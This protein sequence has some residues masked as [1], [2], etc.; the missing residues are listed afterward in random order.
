[1]GISVSLEADENQTIVAT[2]LVNSP[3]QAS[4]FQFPAFQLDIRGLSIGVESPRPL[5]LKKR[6]RED[7]ETEAGRRADGPRLQSYEV[8]RCEP[9]APHKPC[10]ATKVL[11]KT[12]EQVR[13]CR[14][15][16]LSYKA[17]SAT[18]AVASGFGRI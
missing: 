1:M 13:G 12:R 7:F 11:V 8:E 18:T 3:V 2:W 17:R 5:K 15:E 6:P 16:M 14:L 10:C 4:G 9:T